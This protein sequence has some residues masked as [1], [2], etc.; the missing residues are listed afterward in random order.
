MPEPTA[1]AIVTIGGAAV[2]STALSVL[3]VP[4][5]KCKAILDVCEIVDLATE[6]VHDTLERLGVRLVQ[7]VQA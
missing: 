5:A 3:D 6:G 1:T 4:L 7:E 2:T